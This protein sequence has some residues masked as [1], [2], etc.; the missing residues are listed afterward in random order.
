[1]KYLIAIFLFAAML[2]TSVLVRAQIAL[3]QT[4]SAPL[5]TA[6]QESVVNLKLSGKKYMVYTHPQVKLYNLDLTLWKTITLPATVSGYSLTGGSGVAYVS[7]NLFKIDNKVNVV[8]VYDKSGIQNRLV[9]DETGS[10]VF[11]F[12][13]AFSIT[14]YNVGVVNDSF[15]AITPYSG[16]SNTTKVYSLPGT[17]PCN[18][19]G[20][21][22]G[23]GLPVNDELN[24]SASIEAIPNPV[25]GDAKIYY[26][27][28]E[29]TDAASIAL[30]DL[31]GKVIST[32][33]AYSNTPYIVISTSNLAP[34]IYYY[35]LQGGSFNSIT[36]KLVVAK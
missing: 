34:G 20:N 27:L 33:K 23:L 15:V 7:E 11:A 5:G 2:N 13:S 8:A 28:P 30:V 9:I 4:H 21:G 24:N 29:N 31:N 14:V 1:M 6:L 36:K 25:S 17:I 19:C 12:D 3:T 10:L 22:I 16:S 35:T 26:T 18:I 32:Y